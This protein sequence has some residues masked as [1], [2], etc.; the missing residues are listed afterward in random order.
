VA[1]LEFEASY[2]EGFSYLNGIREMPDGRVLAADPLSQVLLRIDLE[3]GTADTLGGVGPGPQEYKQ[4]DQVFPL[5]GDSTLLVDLEKMQLTVIDPDGFF[6]DGIAMT[7]PGGEGFPFILHPRFVDA[8]GSLYDQAP[9]S[10]DEGPQDSVAVIR[11]DRGT[12]TMDTVGMAWFPRP[13][14]IRSRGGGFRQRLLI[15]MDEWAVGPDGRVAII[16]SQDFSVEWRFPDGRTVVGP[17][18]PF[19]TYPIEGPDKEA[20][21]AEI[22]TSGISSTAVASRD[23]SVRQMTMSRGIFRGGDLPQVEDFEWGDHLPRFRPNR[24]L[25]SPRGEV[26]VEPFLP[27]D[28]LPRVEVFDEAGVR[29]GAIMLP[30][31]RRVIGFGEDQ[32]GRELVYLARTDEFDLRWLERYRVVR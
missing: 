1:T 28:S 3:T 14:Q 7:L 13:E 11:Y 29:R 16:R 8:N 4:P 5:P 15:P 31:G 24:T 26:W 30:P 18:N 27:V 20:H 32:A 12:A 17:P 23:G 25:V 9:R 2:P 10:R 21:V 22:R 6:V 19:P